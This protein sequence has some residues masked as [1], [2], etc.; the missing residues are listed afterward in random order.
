MPS[1]CLRRLEYL[2]SHL[3]PCRLSKHP[4]ATSSH[5]DNLSSWSSNLVVGFPQSECSRKREVKLASLIRPGLETDSSISSTIC[6]EEKA[7]TEQPRFKSQGTWTSAFHER[8]SKMLV[9]F[10]EPQSLKLSDRED[11]YSHKFFSHL[12]TSEMFQVLYGLEVKYKH[13][14]FLRKLWYAQNLDTLILIRLL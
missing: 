3:F 9:T 7:V 2:A 10:N 5:R 14:V 1:T 13:I 11:M 6:F 12:K 8:S 4:D